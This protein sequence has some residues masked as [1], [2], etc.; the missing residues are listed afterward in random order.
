MNTPAEF[1]KLD[2]ATVAALVFELAAQLHVERSSR[3]ALE[4]A[5]LQRRVLEPGQIAAAGETAE[6]RAAAARAADES[7]RRL[8][9][10]L[11]ESS[12]HR[13][14]LRAEAPRADGDNP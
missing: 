12:D 4:A 1:G 14:P 5:L 10:V 9:R 11:S 6:L 2:C 13:A 8:L 3:L 7:V